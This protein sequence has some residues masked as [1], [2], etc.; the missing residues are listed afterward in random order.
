MDQNG[1]GE[2]TGIEIH[3]IALCICIYTY[4]EYMYDVLIDVYNY[5]SLYNIFKTA[6]QSYGI[7]ITLRNISVFERLLKVHANKK[8]QLNPISPW[9]PFDLRQVWRCFPQSKPVVLTVPYIIT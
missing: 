9:I 1:E 6:V 2:E 3:Y 5:M 8:T 7:R 4:I